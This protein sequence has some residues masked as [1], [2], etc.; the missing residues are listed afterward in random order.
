MQLMKDNR[1]VCVEIEHY[2]PDL[3]THM[4]VT[5]RGKL[6]VVTDTAKRARVDE[7]MREFGE[8]KLSPNFL[9]AHGLRTTD[10]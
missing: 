7:K 4:F 3:S 9:V 6:K 8:R 1:Q 5:L 10:N 2:D